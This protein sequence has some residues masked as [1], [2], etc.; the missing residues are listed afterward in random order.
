V[1]DYL[2]LRNR[3]DRSAEN[4]RGRPESEL[5]TI[6]QKERCICDR[7]QPRSMG[8]DHKRRAASSRAFDRGTQRLLALGVEIGI[9]LVQQ[10]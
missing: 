8:D 4:F 1:P 10:D 7:Q 3:G 5:H 9:W 6:P 2:R